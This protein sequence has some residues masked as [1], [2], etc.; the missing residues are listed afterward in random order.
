LRAALRET[1]EETGLLVAEPATAR[2]GGAPSGSVW[3]AFAEAGLAPAF[4]RL[5]YVCRAITP[6]SSH[7]RY[8]TRFFLAQGATVAGAIKGDGE[9]DDLGWRSLHE[10]ERLAIVDVTA[11]VLEEALRLWR[12]PQPAGSLPPLACYRNDVFRVRRRA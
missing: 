4:G 3:S 9:L 2:A 11:F 10:I 1:Y 12:T 8:N 5:Q 7:R 6:T